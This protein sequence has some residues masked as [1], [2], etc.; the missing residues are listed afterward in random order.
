ME[1][2]IQSAQSELPRETIPQ[3]LKNM[4]QVLDNSKIFDTQPLLGS[5]VR[6]LLQSFLPDLV[7]EI[8][9]PPPP[10]RIPSPPVLPPNQVQAQPPIQPATDQLPVQAQNDQGQVPPPQPLENVPNNEVQQNQIPVQ[11]A[12]PNQA[13]EQQVNLPQEYGQGQ[14]HPAHLQEQIQRQMQAAQYQMPGQAQQVVGA[15]LQFSN[16]LFGQIPS[17]VPFGQQ[18]VPGQV[19]PQM[20][21]QQQQYPVQDQTLP[22]PNA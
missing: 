1:R 19:V 22:P 18:Q 16:P 2:Y 21:I 10:P 7:K 9:A 8:F 4:I 11:Y 17:P 15:P 13:L 14:M 6:R 5:E 20:P 3:A 12:Q